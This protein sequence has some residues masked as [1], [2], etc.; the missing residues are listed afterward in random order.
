MTDSLHVNPSRPIPALH[1]RPPVRVA[2][3]AW[4]VAATA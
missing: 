2:P 3:R 1:V 4:L